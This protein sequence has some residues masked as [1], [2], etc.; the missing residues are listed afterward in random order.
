MRR[1]RHWLRQSL[2]EGAGGWGREGKTSQVTKVWVGGGLHCMG[3]LLN[4]IRR[5]GRDWKSR[6]QPSLDRAE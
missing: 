4:L 5:D 2:S 6:R 3:P 1:G